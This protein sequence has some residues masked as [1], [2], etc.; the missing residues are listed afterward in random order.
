MRTF[1][2][3]S[4]VLVLSFGI[5]YL[6]LG[7]SICM[8]SEQIGQMA[9]TMDEMIDAT[10]ATQMS[11]GVGITMLLIGLTEG[12]A[13]LFGLLGGKRRGLL[14]ASVALGGLMLISSVRAVLSA[15]FDWMLMIDLALPVLLLIPAVAVLVLDR[16]A[17]R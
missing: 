11:Q 15:P 16:P 7:A 14:I 12:L 1:L 10:A 17:R 9:A 5:Y 3:I 8:G 2:K 4:S 6:L 13:G